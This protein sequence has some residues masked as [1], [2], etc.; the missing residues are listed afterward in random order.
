[1]VS[2]LSSSEAHCMYAKLVQKQGF[3]LATYQPHLKVR[4][5]PLH[6]VDVGHVVVADTDCLAALVSPVR[7]CSVRLLLVLVAFSVHPLAAGSQ[8]VVLPYV[9]NLSLK[10]LML[11]PLGWYRYP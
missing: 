7:L 11:E 5:Q 9:Y 1:M 3:Q 10:R 8:D 6:W 2:A 4:S